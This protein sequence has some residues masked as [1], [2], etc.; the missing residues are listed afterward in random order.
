MNTTKRL[1]LLEDHL[2]VAQSMQYKLSEWGF[3]E[4]KHYKSDRNLLDDLKRGEHFDLLIMDIGIPDTDVERVFAIIRREYPDI[5]VLFLSGSKI[6]SLVSRLMKMGA[7]GYVSKMA[8]L[9]ELSLAIKVIESGEVYVDT[10]IFNNTLL[11]DGDPFD[12]LTPREMKV[13]ELLVAGKSYKEISETLFI[14]VN[15][16]GS[17]CSRINQKLQISSRDELQTLALRFAKFL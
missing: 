8:G 5:N 16:V 2:L 12:K 13:C 14:E 6:P 3:D 9:D 4:F 1:G 10:R 15:T 7:R 17:F 11:H